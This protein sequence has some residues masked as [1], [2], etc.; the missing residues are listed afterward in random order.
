MGT[1]PYRRTSLAEGL[2]SYQP[3]SP[4]STIVE[5]REIRFILFPQ[6]PSWEFV[7]AL[8]QG[9]QRA[10]RLR[11]SR[12]RGPA[13]PRPSIWSTTALRARLYSGFSAH[14]GPSHRGCTLLYALLNLTHA[15][16][17]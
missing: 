11:S 1:R 7:F 2:P 15:G 4:L 13:G 12:P 5:G 6:P 9:R 17:W 14:F 10:I 16:S 3:P 8:W